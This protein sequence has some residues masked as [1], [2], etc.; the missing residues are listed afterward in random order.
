MSKQIGVS[1]I[2]FGYWGPNHCR[3]V[4]HN[5]NSELRMI[6]DTDRLRL[7]TAQEIYPG[8]VCSDDVNKI[9][10]DSSTDVVIIATPVSSHTELVKAAL[11]NN[12]HVLCE[13]P[14]AASIFEIQEI[15]NILKQTDRIFMSAHIY[16]FNPIVKYI[17]NFLKYN[18]IGQLLYM[19]TSRNGLGPIRKDINVVFDLATHDISIV[20]FLLDKMPQAVAAFG[21]SY[22]NNGIED[23]AF[24]QLEFDDKLYVSI[25]VS[26]LDPIKERKIRIVGSKKMLLFNDISIDEKLKI[27][28]T[29]ESYLNF[30]GDFGSFQSTIKDG[31]IYIPNIHFEEP[32]AAQFNHFMDCVTNNK[33]P[34]TDISNARRV[35]QILE[36]LNQSLKNNGE[37]IR[38]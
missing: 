8:I 1:V 7:K 34:S 18:D 25:Q 38:L 29:G 17:K 14:V 37:R 36:A 13:K 23:V 27:Y 6:C 10:S 35:L 31:D 30:T 21:K 33:Q 5:K 32:L 26:W 28:N 2:G 22:F 16:E 15:D 9:F 12:K 24:I 20:L 4:Q 19:S 3:I 11:K